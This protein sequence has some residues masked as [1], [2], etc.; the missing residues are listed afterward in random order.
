MKFPTFWIRL[1]NPN[2]TVTARGW[3]DVSL[4]EA[5]RNAQ[6]RL[7]RILAALKSKHRDGLDRYSYVIDNVI[8]E[9]VIDRIVDGSPSGQSKFDSFFPTLS[10]RHFTNNSVFLAHQRC[11]P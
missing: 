6:N 10:R 4:D 2:G 11:L 5:T 9:E 7:I 3:S 8:C 1:Q